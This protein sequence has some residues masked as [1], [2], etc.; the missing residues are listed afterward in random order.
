MIFMML[1]VKCP[2]REKTFK[3]LNVPCMS[4]RGEICSL[5]INEQVSEN[6][7]VEMAKVTALCQVLHT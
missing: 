1:I 7:A 3:F 5:L 6:E 2:G 4:Q